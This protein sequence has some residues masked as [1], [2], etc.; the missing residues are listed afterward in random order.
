VFLDLC[1]IPTK[2]FLPHAIIV[3]TA[4]RNPISGTNNYSA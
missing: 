4:D 1:K 3:C 2:I